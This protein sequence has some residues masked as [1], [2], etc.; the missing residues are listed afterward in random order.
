MKT[1]GSQNLGESKFDITVK[2]LKWIKKDVDK[3]LE[4]LWSSVKLISTVK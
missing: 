3:K 1:E 4:I 2:Y